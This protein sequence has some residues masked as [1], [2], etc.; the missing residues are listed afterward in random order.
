MKQQVINRCRVYTSDI[1]LCKKYTSTWQSSSSVMICIFLIG[2][3][4]QITSTCSLLNTNHELTH[5]KICC[6]LLHIQVFGCVWQERI[7]LGIFCVNQ[8]PYITPT[9]QLVSIHG[10]IGSFLIN[11]EF[12]KHTVFKNIPY[13]KFGDCKLETIIFRGYASFKEGSL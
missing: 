1:F 3:P 6:S 8:Y 11:H 4:N 7:L 2:L 12:Q 10:G 9:Q 5:L 13:S